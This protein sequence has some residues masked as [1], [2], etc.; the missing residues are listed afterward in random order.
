MSPHLLSTNDL[1]IVILSQ[2]IYCTFSH[3]IGQIRRSSKYY[4]LLRHSWGG[5]TVGSKQSFEP[6]NETDT[7]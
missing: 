3:L 1:R 5:Q 7:L 4:N 6:G 2:I